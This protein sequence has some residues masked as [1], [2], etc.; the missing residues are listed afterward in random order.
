MSNIL[1]IALARRMALRNK[2][3]V[4]A[5]NIANANTAAYRGEK[6]L[7]RKFLEKT[8][9]GEEYVTVQDYRTFRDITEGSLRTTNNALDVA[10]QGEGYFA[11]QGTRGIRYTRQGQFSLD[12][13]RNLVNSS[14]YQVLDDAQAAINIPIEA[15][16]I[17]IAPDGTISSQIGIIG[18]IG[19]VNFEAPQQMDRAEDGLYI[20]EQ[21]II[22]IETPILV[23]GML[24]ESNIKPIIEITEMMQILRETQRLQK[25]IDNQHERIKKMVEKIGNPR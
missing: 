3:D 10:I 8:G 25:I 12:L 22:P 18:T 14:G 4:V 6:L 7:F 1:D 15:T 2:M 16:D 9:H 17:T 5:H 20:T 13:D 11:V 23:Q 19:V 24:E 21:P